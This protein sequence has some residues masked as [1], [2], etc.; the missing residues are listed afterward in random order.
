MALTVSTEEFQNALMVL[1]FVLLMLFG[2]LPD[3]LAERREV[4]LEEERR[5]DRKKS[6]DNLKNCVCISGT[7]QC[8]VYHKDL[9]ALE[10][11]LDNSKCKHIR[12]IF[13]SFKP[14]PYV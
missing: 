8:P 1:G 12:T 14:N 13:N 10:K 7:D 3:I 2:I 5:R 6:S 9:K 11:A 4:I